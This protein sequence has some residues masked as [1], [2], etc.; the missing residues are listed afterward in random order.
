MEKKRVVLTGSKLLITSTVRWLKKIFELYIIDIK[1]NE[2]GLSRVIGA[3]NAIGLIHGGNTFISEFLFKNCP[4]LRWSV[5]PGIEPFP[6]FNRA[7]LNLCQDHLFPVYSTGGGIRAVVQT[8]IEQISDLTLLKKRAAGR[9]IDLPFIVDKYHAHETLSVIGLG[10]MGKE[11]LLRCK[12]RGKFDKVIFSGRTDNL[13]FTEKTGIPFRPMEEAFRADVVILTI[14]HIAGVTDNYVGH[15]LMHQ[16]N[17]HGLL[18]NNVRPQIMDIQRTFDFAM[19]RDDVTIIIDA[20]LAEIE[21]EYGQTLLNT[22][23]HHPNIVFTGHTA[24][25]KPYTRQEYSAGVMK[26]ITEN[27]LT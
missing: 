21:R 10:N 16:I 11:I 22:L 5:F 15:D 25:K 14:A 8:T 1:I 26:I 9:R 23:K 13:E 19:V 18:I 20:S 27:N 24:W 7:A 2:N 12:A 17:P 6:T 3:H 4:S